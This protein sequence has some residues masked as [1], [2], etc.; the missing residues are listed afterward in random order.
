MKDYTIYC[1]EGQTK[2]AIE[3]GAPIT[4]GNYILDSDELSPIG[5]I[6]GVWMYAIIPTVEQ[7][8]G[9]LEEQGIVIIFMPT[10]KE[11]LSG[12]TWIAHICHFEDKSE[13]VDTKNL[14]YQEATLAAIDAALEYLLTTKTK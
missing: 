9:W 8:R 7:M 2:K 3:L 14:S 4:Y 12:Y 5:D 13:W 11:D 10:M 1:T 6:D